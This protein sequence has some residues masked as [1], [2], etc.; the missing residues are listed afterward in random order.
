MSI[1]TEGALT[2]YAVADRG[3]VHLRANFVAGLDGAATLEGRSGTLGDEEDQRVLRALRALADVLL[4]GA[5]TLRAE[6]Y[7]ALRLDDAAV[8]WRRAN[9]LPDHPVLAVVTGSL[10]LHPGADALAQA[11]VR[12]LVITH[13]AA[14]AERRAALAEVADV[15]SCG[16]QAVD[17]AA[18][19]SALAGRGLPQILCEGG[20]SLFGSF[21][22]A[23]AVDEL[24]LTLA[25]VLT[26]GGAPRIA[27]ADQEVARDMELVHALP[28]KAMLFL[29][30]LRSGRAG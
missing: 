16:E 15:V 7:G 11:P 13:A 26:A 12:P 4:V 28:G 3:A 10:D 24:C 18:V 30:Y 5:G 27:V 23:D 21:V 14:P 25:P 17:P 29:R 22:V 6:G 1:T 19:R 2:R 9:G 8:G 20:P